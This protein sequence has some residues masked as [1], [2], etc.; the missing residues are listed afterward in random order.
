[1]NVLLPWNQDFAL[2]KQLLK[3]FAFCPFCVDLDNP[4]FHLALV[5]Q[6]PVQSASLVATAA[7]PLTQITAL[8]EMQ[9]QK[10]STFL[11]FFSVN[12]ELS[13]LVLV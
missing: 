4:I 5:A 6:L 3:L 9:Q 2:N 12:A 1:M 13:T 8:S 7:P 10:K 11:S